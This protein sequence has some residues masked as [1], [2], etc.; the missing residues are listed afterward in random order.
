MVNLRSGAP[1]PMPA[2]YMI[3]LGLRA[4]RPYPHP[5]P[6]RESFHSIAS[7]VLGRFSVSTARFMILPRITPVSRWGSSGVTRKRKHP[8]PSEHKIRWRCGKN[9]RL[10]YRGKR[11]TAKNVKLLISGLQ[12]LAWRVHQI[13]KKINDISFRRSVVSCQAIL[14]TSAVGTPGT[15]S[16]SARQAGR[17]LRA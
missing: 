13:T 16:D 5:K 17:L 7:P 6:A 2:R 14:R 4:A 8:D 9:Q 11:G 10:A 15:P 1:R 12:V 3:R